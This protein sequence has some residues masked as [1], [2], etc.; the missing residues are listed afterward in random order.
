MCDVTNLRIGYPILNH[1]PMKLYGDHI[2]SAD[3][4]MLFDDFKL[5]LKN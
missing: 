2:F 3:T 5:Y 1:H 4:W